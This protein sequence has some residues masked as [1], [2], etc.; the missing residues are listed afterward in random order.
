MCVAGAC[1]AKRQACENG[2]TAAATA[3]AEFTTFPLPTTACDPLRIVNGAD[4]N[5][6]FVE[7]GCNKVG[8]ITTTGAITEFAIPS[9]DAYP[10]GIAAG[11]DGNLWF[12]EFNLGTLGRITP[13]G[14]LTEIPCGDDGT[15]HDNGGLAVSSTGSLWITDSNFIGR[16]TTAGTVTW[17]SLPTRNSYPFGITAGR[18]GD[19]WFV[20]QATGNVGHVTPTGVITEF[21]VVTPL[22]TSSGAVLRSIVMGPDG[23]LWFTETL[24]NAIGRMSPDGLSIEHFPVLTPNSAVEDITVGPDGNLWFTAYHGGHIG[25]VTPSGTVTELAVPEAGG[26][27][28]IVVGRD[29]NLWITD[30]DWTANGSGNSIHRFTM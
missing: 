27:A 21:P 5:L 2:C 29:G 24:N 18:D 16:A 6:W 1:T 7:P 10:N 23:N 3:C 22:A 4:G 13:A 12:T 19:M 15:V 30:V 8:R 14:V 9:P 26:L 11:P 25:R 20:E 28:G 17:Y